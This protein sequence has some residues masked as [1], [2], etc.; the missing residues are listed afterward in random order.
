MNLL[1]AFKQLDIINELLEKKN[2]KEKSSINKNQV[3]T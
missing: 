1:E 2:N 3:D